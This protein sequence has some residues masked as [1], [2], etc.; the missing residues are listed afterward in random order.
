[1]DCKDLPDQEL[2]ESSEESTPPYAETMEGVL[3]YHADLSLMYKH[4]SNTAK[5]NFKK[6]FYRKKMVKNNRKLYSLLVRTPN[7]YNP[8]MKYL[9]NEAG[10]GEAG[11]T[12][13]SEESNE[14]KDEASAQGDE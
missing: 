5:T 14:Q 7:E 3:Q 13:I 11:E 12:P 2:D 9:T 6:E 1:M 4:L 10:N 8:L